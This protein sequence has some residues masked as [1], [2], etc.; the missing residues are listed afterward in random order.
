M[1]AA[2][3]N[4][5]LMGRLGV[6]A[7]LSGSLY[8]V[9]PAHRVDAARHLAARKIWAHADVFADT[10]AGV[11]LELIGRLGDA[12]A[13]PVDVHLLTAEALS[14]LELVCRPGIARVTFPFERVPDVPAVA[15]R[16]RAAGP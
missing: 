3:L 11:S 5:E 10:S 12:G 13:G 7:Q 15:E 6:G 8:A 9:P 16:I 14:A 1:S 2:P 4:T